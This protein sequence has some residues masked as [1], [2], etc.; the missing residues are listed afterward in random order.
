MIPNSAKRMTIAPV[1]QRVDKRLD[2][3]HER[4]DQ[5]ETRFDRLSARMDARFDS[6]DETLDAILGIL[7]NKSSGG[8]RTYPFATS[9]AR[10]RKR[11]ARRWLDVLAARCTNGAHNPNPLTIPESARLH[12]RAFA[13]LEKR[14]KTLCDAVHQCIWDRMDR[15]GRHQHGRMAQAGAE[16]R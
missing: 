9:C 15:R 10:G 1:T 13:D 12:E 6:M 14:D 7:G 3:I 8:R 16:E 2:A 5:V 11:E 4:F